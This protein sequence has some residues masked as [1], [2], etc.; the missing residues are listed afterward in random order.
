MINRMNDEELKAFV[1]GVCD[2]KIFTS[3][4]VADLDTHLLGSIFM[5]LMFLD[6]EQREPLRHDLGIVWEHLAKANDRALNGY[7]T[8]FSMR[9]MHKDDWDRAR[10]AIKKE[11]DRRK[12]IQV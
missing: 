9:V 1:L 2:D 5:P 12:E 7:P 6:E 8:F 11:Q 4:H 3:M 10:A